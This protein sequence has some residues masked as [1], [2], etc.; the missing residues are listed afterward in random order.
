MGT[1]DYMA[2][3]QAQ[4]AEVDERADVYAL[5]CVLFRALTGVLPYERTSDVDKMWAHVHE[6]PPHLLDARPD[7][8]SA[9]APVLERALAKS[10]DDRPASAGELA[11]DALAAVA[12]R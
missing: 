7:L 6:P 8:P 4:G 12:S 2:P 11:R 1:A 9:S 5:G 10:P 3:E